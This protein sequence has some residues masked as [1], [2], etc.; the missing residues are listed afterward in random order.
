MEIGEVVGGTQ[1]QS[2]LLSERGRDFMPEVD[3]TI[4]WAFDEPLEEFH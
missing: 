4:G 1:L 2:R 3:Y